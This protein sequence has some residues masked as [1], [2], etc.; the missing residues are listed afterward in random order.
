MPD[1]LNIAGEVIDVGWNL[2]EAFSNLVDV[3]T[4]FSCMPKVSRCCARLTD[5]YGW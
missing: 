3:N 1:L 2:R 4:H 5:L